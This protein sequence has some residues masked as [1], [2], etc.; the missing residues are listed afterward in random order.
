L[1]YGVLSD[2]HGNFAAL[3]AVWDA[4]T[5]EGL[6][7]DQPVLNAGDNVGYG[8]APFECL[9][10]LQDRP[11]ILT[12]QGNYDKNVALFPEKEAEYRKK[13]GK[14]RPEKFDALKR[15]S[16][17]ITDA[18]R[19]WLLELPKEQDLTL[20]GTRIV[21]THYSPGGKEG[22]GRWTSDT[23]L[24]EIA[25]ETPAQVVI[26]GHTHSP[27]IRR[28]GGVLFVNPGTVGRSWFGGACYGILTLDSDM[29]PVAELLQVKK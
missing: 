14:V 19:D 28:V 22:L 3:E 20:D 4:L 6:T 21:L 15:D 25:E 17:L 16:G 7:A 13:W 2:I 29:P 12:V 10:F 9:R 11:N 27:F 23:R 24:R 18:D 5:R 8:N 1:R 26:C